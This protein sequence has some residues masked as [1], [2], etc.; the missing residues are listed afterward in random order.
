MGAL[1]YTESVRRVL[2]QGAHG[3]T[4]GGSPLAC[5]AGLAALAT[6][7]DERLIDRSASLGASM[8]IRYGTHSTASASFA[9]FA[10]SG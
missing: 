10:G 4:F 7:R 8:S 9:T 6:Y 2:Y 5:A 1:A 3:S